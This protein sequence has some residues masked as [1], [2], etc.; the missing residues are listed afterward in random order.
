MSIKKHDYEKRLKAVLAVI[1]DYRSIRSVAIEMGIDR[2]EVRC[3]VA[4]YKQFGKDGLL[5]KNGYYS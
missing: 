4:F 3:L 1:E 5:I 2:K